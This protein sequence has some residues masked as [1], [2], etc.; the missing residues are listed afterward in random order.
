MAVRRQGAPV[1][2]ARNCHKSVYSALVLS[3][4]RPVYL[5]PEMTDMNIAGGINPRSVERALEANKS[6][7]AVVVTSPTYEG[8]TSDIPAIAEIAHRHGVPLIV[9][10][11]HGAVFN[12]HGDL[13]ESAVKCGADIVVHSL[14]K[15]L[16]MLSQTAAMHVNE[17]LLDPVSVK[18]SVNLIQST[19]PSYIFLAQ[20]DYALN[21][22]LAEPERM[23]GYMAMIQEFRAAFPR[24]GTLSLVG[25][26]YAGKNSIREADISKFVIYINSMGLS[27]GRLERILADN[28]GLQAELSGVAH[29]I[30]MT[31]PADT[32]EGMERLLNAV[33]S[34]NAGE[35]FVGDFD[36]ME[37]IQAPPRPQVALTPRDAFYE[38]ARPVKLQDAKSLVSASFIIP[39]PPGIPL[40]APGEI[41]TADILSYIKLCWDS[42]INVIGADENILVCSLS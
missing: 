20:V 5:F 13:P 26:E 24:E 15:R 41:I 27:G 7:A 10:E 33:K 42:G 38:K 16:P 19:S 3:G 18:K 6:A 40:V 35:V 30:A 28:Y 23:G 8:F 4:M 17:G 9:D 21:A 12:F 2:I 39:Y 11:A 1:I 32:R 31:T 29:I 14:H 25:E 22:L 34:V 36:G 37:K